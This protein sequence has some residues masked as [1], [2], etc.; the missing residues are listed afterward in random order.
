MHHYHL[1]LYI[2]KFANIKNG[3]IYLCIFSIS[4]AKIYKNQISFA[5]KHP[6]STILK[7][8]RPR[9]LVARNKAE[10]EGTK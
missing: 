7:N 2:C 6:K 5:P 1:C 10:I 3:R 4:N 8:S 9:A